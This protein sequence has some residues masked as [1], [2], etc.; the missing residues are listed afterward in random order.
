MWIV[1]CLAIHVGGGE[2][3]GKGKKNLGTDLKKHLQ[4][5]H[6]GWPLGEEDKVSASGTVYISAF[7]AA[8]FK[9]KVPW[10]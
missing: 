2:S 10:A 4:F 9:I 8:P 7:K 5:F 1:I 3:S 6:W